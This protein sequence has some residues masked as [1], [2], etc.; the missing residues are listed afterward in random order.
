VATTLTINFN[1][2]G[3]IG[4]TSS[5]VVVNPAAPASLAF[6]QPPSDA[7]AGVAIS[8]AVTVRAQDSLGNNVP[9]V[10]VNMSLSTGNGSLSGTTTRSTDTNGLATFND[11][12]VNL[13]GTK[14][15]TASSGALSTGEISAFT[16]SPA[17]AARLTVLTQPSATATAG[18]VFSQQAVIRIEDQFGN[19]QSSDNSTV[20]SASRSS[21]TASGVLQ[22]STKLVASGGVVAFTNLSYYVAETMT[23]GFSASGLTTATSSNVVVSPVAFTQLQ[24]LVPGETAAP[25]T[26]T[27][28]TGSPSARTAGT[29]FN[30]TVTP[31]D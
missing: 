23:I 10:S 18:T 24:L 21:G 9:G 17:A 31:A 14:K 5:N 6:V 22:G 7:L 20:V 4:A 15:L 30:V 25:G 16:I 8:P 11:L 12:N 13:V 2:P 3:L 27:G 19:L 26:A 28:Q 29:A 1:A